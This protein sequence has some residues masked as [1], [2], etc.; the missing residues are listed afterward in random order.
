ML[1]D[2]TFDTVGL[3]DLRAKGVTCRSC[4]RWMPDGCEIGR[5]S[6]PRVCRFYEY[7]PGSDAGVEHESDSST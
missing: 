4:E 2:P 5:P 6:Y 7:L 1:S 3:A